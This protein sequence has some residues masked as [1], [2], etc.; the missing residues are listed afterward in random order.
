M[1]VLCK[2]VVLT[3]EKDVFLIASLVEG[4]LNALIQKEGSEHYPGL[5]FFRNPEYKLCHTELSTSSELLSVNFSFRGESRLLN[6][7]FSCDVDHCDLANKSISMSMGLSG[8]SDLY[9]KTVL[10]ALSILGPAYFSKDDG[11]DTPP[12]PLGFFTPTLMNLIAMG[13]YSPVYARRFV[14]AFNA[15]RFRADC[16]FEKVIG[17]RY[18]WM[19]HKLN[20]S[21]DTAGA[22]AISE[23]AKEISYPAV[24]YEEDL[25]TVAI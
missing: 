20:F 19:D 3:P 13:V 11:R 9:I 25:S 2:G 1:S 22:C 7:F 4:A 18:S 17:E 24:Q 15:G 14:A 23:R 5:S 16:T 6:V 8:H 21:D 12:K 10:H